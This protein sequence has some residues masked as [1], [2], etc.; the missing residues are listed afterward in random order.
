MPAAGNPLAKLFGGLG[1]TQGGIPMNNTM[2][3]GGPQ[4]PNSFAATNP[5]AAMMSQSMA[6][7]HGGPKPPQRNAGS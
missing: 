3:A 6:L 7:P 4:G 5:L 2:T 1:K